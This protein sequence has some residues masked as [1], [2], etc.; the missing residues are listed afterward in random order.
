MKHYFSTSIVESHNR[1]N[2]GKEIPGL[3]SSEYSHQEHLQ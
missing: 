2:G 3:G 1:D